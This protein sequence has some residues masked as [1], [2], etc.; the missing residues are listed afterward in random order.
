MIDLKMILGY[1]Y[2]YK[3]LHKFIGLSCVV[4]EA[5]TGASGLLH[6]Q[7]SIG[8]SPGWSCTEGQSRRSAEGE[9]YHVG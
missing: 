7:V 6:R 9:R 1:Q 4:P 3:C 5:P 2:L 8:R